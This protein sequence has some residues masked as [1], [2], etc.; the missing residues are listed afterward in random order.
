MSAAACLLLL[1]FPA[2]AA[3]AGVP[4][5]EKKWGLSLP[6]L[7]GFEIKSER[8]ADDGTF[9]IFEAEATQPG[10]KR[11]AR[12]ELTR[13]LPEAAAKALVAERVAAVLELYTRKYKG[14]FGFERKKCSPSKDVLGQAVLLE[15]LAGAGG[16]FGACGKEARHA[17]LALILHCPDQKAVLELSYYLPVAD[18][19][20]EARRGLAELACP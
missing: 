7:R 16:E 20:V 11:F 4:E 12:L 18:E 19:K 3:A 5:L 2:T 8:A 1:L 13:G 17:V 9:R 10:G 14:K 15:G 6:L